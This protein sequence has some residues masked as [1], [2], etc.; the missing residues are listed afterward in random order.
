MIRS[1]SRSVVSLVAIAAWVVTIPVGCNLLL[2][3][4]YVVGSGDGST[5]PDVITGNDA[6]PTGD[7][8]SDAAGDADACVTNGQNKAQLES[9]CTN[10]TCEPFDNASRNTLCAEGGTACPPVTPPSDAAPP[11]TGAAP[12][13]GTGVDGAP[14]DAAP[15]DAGVSCFALTT[16]P[17]GGALPKPFVYATGSTAI[18]PYMARVAQVL[19]SL[20]IGT[21][22][23]EGAGSCFGVSGMLSPTTNTLASIAPT[24]TYYDPALDS[25]GQVQSG[26]CVIDDPTQIADL[27]VSD[28]FPTT[29]DAQLIA[30]GG[31]PNNL[32]DFF[33]PVQ[34][35]ELVVPTTSTQTSISTE[36]AYMVWGFGAGSG[37]SPW[38]D[39]A[40]L[41]QRNASSGTQN[42]IAATIGL[43]A[44]DWVD[45]PNA[46]STGVLTG[47]ENVAKDLAID[48][49]PG[50]PANVDKTMGILA[51]DVA[52]SNRMYLKPLAFQ[53]LGESCGWYPDSTQTSFDKDNVRDGHYPIWGPSHL[54]AYADANGNATNPAV[55]TLIDSMN[56]RNQQLNATLDVIQFY[57]TSHI[58][59]TCAMHVQRTQDGHDYSPYAPPTSCSCYYDLQA[60][61]QTSCTKCSMDA[62]CQNAPNGA[63]TCVNV[64]GIPPVGY[65]E[66]PGM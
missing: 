40:F 64:F 1:R 15:V 30:A 23:Y 11:D 12:D 33:G 4:G 34:V 9:A 17:A 32:H 43:P 38:T 56:G 50:S 57:A 6:L 8:G 60:T 65:C 28:V 61:G 53:D 55:K 29:C 26:T 10:S 21:V 47:I 7:G 22:V 66:P 20:S 31:L 42:M 41:L 52:D 49:G 13:T 19:E 63:T 3:G 59:P 51:S 44:A 24:A 35:M 48:G 36:A 27:G 58:V 54:I 39:P 25:N 5:G 16:G 2:G 45:T 14:A 18:Q 62:D 46:T 37:V